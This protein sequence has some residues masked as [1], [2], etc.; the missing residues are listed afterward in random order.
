LCS[1]DCSCRWGTRCYDSG[2][3]NH[4]EDDGNMTPCLLPSAMGGGPSTNME[5]VD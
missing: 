1:P 5:D 3:E 2:G 4:D